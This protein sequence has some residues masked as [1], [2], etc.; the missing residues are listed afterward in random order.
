MRPDWQ[1]KLLKNKPDVFHPG[2]EWRI[3]GGGDEA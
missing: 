3:A 1:R 2:V